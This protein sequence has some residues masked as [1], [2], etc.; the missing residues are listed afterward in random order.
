MSIFLLSN[1]VDYTGHIYTSR[2]P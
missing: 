1:M 2:F